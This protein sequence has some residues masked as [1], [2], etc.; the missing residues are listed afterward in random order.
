MTD[1][2]LVLL[3]AWYEGRITDTEFAIMWQWVKA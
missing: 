2:E 1:W 3:R